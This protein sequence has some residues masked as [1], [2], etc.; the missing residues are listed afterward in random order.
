MAWRP[1]RRWFSDKNNA[2]VKQGQAAEERERE[3]GTGGAAL[4]H[5]GGEAAAAAAAMQPPV[6]AGGASRGELAGGGEGVGGAPPSP[7]VAVGSQ[8]AGPHAQFVAHVKTLACS[9]VNGIAQG[10][11]LPPLSGQ[12]TPATLTTAPLPRSPCLPRRAALAI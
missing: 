3:E 11:V 2:W 9:Y 5:G 6:A 8:A 12:A 7:S 10:L 4:A 1:A